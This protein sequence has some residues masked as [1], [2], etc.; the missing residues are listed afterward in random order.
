MKTRLERLIALE[1]KISNGYYPSVKGICEMFDIKAR[2]AY[3]DIKLLRTNLGLDVRFDRSRNGYYNA[4]PSIRLP[5]YDLS[6]DQFLL[7]VVSSSMLL[8]SLG[9][10]FGPILHNAIVKIQR[11]LKH[12]K[13]VHLDD[14]AAIVKQPDTKNSVLDQQIWVT[15]LS[16]CLKRKC[17]AVR[18]TCGSESASETTVERCYL[19]E[20]NGTW[21]LI[22]Y[23]R[24][25]ESAQTL[26]LHKISSCRLLDQS[27]SRTPANQLPH[28]P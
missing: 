17:L 23:F 6:E 8:N 3:E 15:V 2:T 21:L 22:A 19:S 5:N 28:F 20:S 11:R 14:V 24:E 16:A 9:D 25:L 10:S 12:S 1:A 26:P 4:S 13:D 18:H 27:C 7:L